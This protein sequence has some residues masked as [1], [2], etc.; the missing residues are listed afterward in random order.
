MGSKPAH[1]GSTA[2]ERMLLV[3]HQ[4]PKHCLMTNLMCV[5]P[6][7]VGCVPIALGALHA[8]LM[9]GSLPP[10]V[11]AT[12]AQIEKMTAVRSVASKL[13]EALVSLV[14]NCSLYL[15]LVSTMC[16]LY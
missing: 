4:Y 8:S 14:N 3:L 12:Y 10:G 5:M 13:L 16:C 11:S 7:L 1:M 9:V 2:L 15:M 6:I